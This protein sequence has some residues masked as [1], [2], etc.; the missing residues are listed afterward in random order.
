MTKEEHAGGTV[1]VL[2]DVELSADNWYNYIYS[3]ALDAAPEGI[4]LLEA[5]PEVTLPE[6]YHTEKWF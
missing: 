6:K 2:A 5:K 4:T 1:D 3:T